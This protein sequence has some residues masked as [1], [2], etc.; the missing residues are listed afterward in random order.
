[1]LAFYS[2]SFNG[3]L[4]IGALLAGAAADWLGEPQTVL[5][6]GALLLAFGIAL[7]FRAPRLRRLE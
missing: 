3:L 2:L 7:W 5:V 6:S 4:P 1:V